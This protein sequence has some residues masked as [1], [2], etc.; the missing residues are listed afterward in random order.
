MMSPADSII[1][2]M[3]DT[4]F[5]CADLVIGA[6][7]PPPGKTRE[8]HLYGEIM[9]VINAVDAIHSEVQEGRS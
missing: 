6:K 4:L 7:S 1:L 5:S 3:R 8:E 2:K 9:R